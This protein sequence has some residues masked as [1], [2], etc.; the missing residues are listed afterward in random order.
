MQAQ[1]NPLNNPD[2]LS[3]DDERVEQALQSAAKRVVDLGFEAPVCFFLQAHLP[4]TTIA[5]TVGLLFQP[6]ATPLFGTERVE[7]MQLILSERKN[8]ERLEELIEIYALANKD[9]KA[10]K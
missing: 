7:L 9:R 8:V 3:P 2:Q 6:I 1:T 5:H 10:N 4:F